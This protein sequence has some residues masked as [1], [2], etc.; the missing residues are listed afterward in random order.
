MLPLIVATLCAADPMPSAH[1]AAVRAG[2]LAVVPVGREV[3]NAGD[4]ATCCGL[5]EGAIIA[6]RPALD[7]RPALQKT[8]DTDLAAAKAITDLSERAFAL[9][10]LIDETVAALAPAGDKPK[11]AAAGLSADEQAVFELSNQE[12]KKAGLPPLVV[13]EKL[14]Q[15]ARAHSV[16]MA[17]L[18]QLEHT[19]DDKGPG[20]RI[21]EVKYRHRGWAE[22]VAA[23][24]RTPPEVVSSWMN[25]EGH[26]AN[27]LGSHR[28]FGVG[29]AKAADGTRY[30]TQVFA[31]P[32]E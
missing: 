23:G 10:K 31:T 11:A 6:C 3:F 18:N 28:E 20:E 27:L 17:R 2:L 5:F 25:S 22:N 21:D 12:R 32:A 30:W 15:A 26:K 14:M 29:V 7:H 19:L 13:N 4:P 24:Q 9:R 1:D 8:I 16:N